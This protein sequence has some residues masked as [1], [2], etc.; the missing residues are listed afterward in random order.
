MYILSASWSLLRA[1]EALEAW[2]S[3]SCLIHLVVL[4]AQFRGSVLVRKMF[5][6][7]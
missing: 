2:M 1:F 4:E 3:C 5:V 6:F 7:T